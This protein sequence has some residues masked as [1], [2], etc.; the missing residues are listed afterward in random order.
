MVSTREQKRI[1]IVTALRQGCS[2]SVIANKFIV[3]LDTV[4]RWKKRNIGD[5]EKIVCEAI[6]QLGRPRSA[7]TAKNV[8]K[9][10]RIAQV[11]E[12][13]VNQNSCAQIE[14]KP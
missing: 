14:H 4:K 11:K 12:K 7:R 5:R 6:K 9:S 13:T 2:N 3:C 8:R 1:Q 10:V